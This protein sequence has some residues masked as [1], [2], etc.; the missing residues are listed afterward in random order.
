MISGIATAAVYVAYQDEA[1][2]FWTTQVG[3]E[4]RRSR[5]MTATARW[6]EVGPP[7]GQSSLVLYPREMMDDWEQRR[8]SLVFECDDIERTYQEMARR[9][10]AFPER[11]REMAWGKFAI[12]RDPDGNEYGLREARAGGIE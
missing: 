4:V 6:I 2:Q 5:P 10:V 9:G 3:F 7:G 11:P 1:V 12:F 8:P